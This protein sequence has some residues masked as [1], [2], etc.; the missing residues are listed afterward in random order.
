MEME[1]GV[2]IEGDNG[3]LEV[4]LIYNTFWTQD[5]L[6]DRKTSTSM[7]AVAAPSSPGWRRGGG[8]ERELQVGT[9]RTLKARWIRRCG[10]RSTRS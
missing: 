5:L 6:K 1:S 3:K 2:H 8:E 10:S 7:W 4:D 9:V